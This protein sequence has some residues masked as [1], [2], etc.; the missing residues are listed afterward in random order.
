MQAQQQ[1]NTPKQRLNVVAII[2]VVCNLYPLF[3][4]SRL[5]YMFLFRVIGQPWDFYLTGGLTSLTALGTLLA[6]VTII[7]RQRQIAIY[8]QSLAAA[9]WTGHTLF[10]IWSILTNDDLKDMLIELLIYN[11]VPDLTL[12]LL[13]A[14][15]VWFLKRSGNDK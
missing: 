7:L 10:S 12:S 3:L 1:K 15:L 5:A 11:A 6:S 13:L 14:A 9:A 2:V 8:S 4:S